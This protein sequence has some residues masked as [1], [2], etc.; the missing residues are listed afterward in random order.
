MSQL[1]R[2]P[3]WLAKYRELFARGA[4]FL[5]EG[6]F[7]KEQLVRLGCPADKVIVQH[8]G[9]DCAKFKYRERKLNPGEPVRILIAAAFREKKGI[10]Y[11]LKAFAQVYQKNPDIR[12]RILGDGPLRARI[13]RLIK[14]LGIATVVTMLGEQPYAVFRDELERAHLFLSPSVTASDGDTE[15][16]CPV[17]IIEAQAT[18]LPV[19]STFH[20]DIPEVVIHGKTGLLAPEKNVAVLADNLSYLVTHPEVWADMGRRGREHVEREYNVVHQ[21]ARLEDIYESILDRSQ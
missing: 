6:N 18:G 11:A 7:M 1:V 14:E 13:E 10:E 5:V 17:A 8:I 3:F 19:L 2:D 12:L 20:A 4:A 16:G 9:V 21:I 15:G